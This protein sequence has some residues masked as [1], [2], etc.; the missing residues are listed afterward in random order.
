MIESAAE[1]ATPAD[2]RLFTYLFQGLLTRSISESSSI[3]VKARPPGNETVVPSIEPQISME[4]TQSRSRC[5]RRSAV[6]VIDFDGLGQTG[7]AH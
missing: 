3:N 6:R 1:T 4:D 5:F 7:P 2:L